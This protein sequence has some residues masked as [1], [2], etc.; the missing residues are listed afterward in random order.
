MDRFLTL[1]FAL[2]TWRKSG[3]GLILDLSVRVGDLEMHRV[4]VYS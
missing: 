2:V 3:S 1:V 4:L